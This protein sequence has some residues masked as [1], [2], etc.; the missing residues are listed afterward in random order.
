MNKRLYEVLEPKQDK[1][2]F[3]FNNCWTI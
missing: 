2:A 3:I 1:S